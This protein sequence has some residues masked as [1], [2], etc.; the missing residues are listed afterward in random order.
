ML[1]RTGLAKLQTDF[2]EAVGKHWGLELGR[3]GSSRKH[4][5]TAE[6]KAKKI[7][8]NAVMEAADITE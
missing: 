4:L 6:Y 2:H 1:N 7:V 5:S 3:E 8:M